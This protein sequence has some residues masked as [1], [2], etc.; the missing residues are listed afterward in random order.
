MS[1]GSSRYHNILAG[2]IEA[3]REQCLE[4]QHGPRRLGQQPAAVFDPDVTAALQDVDT[5][6]RI[7]RMADDRLVFLAPLE[8]AEL[9]D[10]VVGQV[11]VVGSECRPP[12]GLRHRR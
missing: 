5:A 7:V 3:N 4:Q 1:L 6:E 11:G 9:E 12:R 8:R 2:Q 10:D